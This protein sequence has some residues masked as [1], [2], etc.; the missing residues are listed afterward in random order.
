MIIAVDYGADRYS[1]RFNVVNYPG[2]NEATWSCTSA[3]S[4]KCTNWRAQS[5]P[6]GS[7]KLAAQLLKIT[8]SKGKTVEQSY[9]KYYFSF[10]ISLTNP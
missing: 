7:G 4:G 5:D 10:D 6:N 3:A 9:G 1:I 2:T 8:T